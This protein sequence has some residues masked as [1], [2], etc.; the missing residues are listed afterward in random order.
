M[1]LP[2][3]RKLI[4]FKNN[5]LLS[6][7]LLKP[8]T[9]HIMKPAT[10]GEIIVIVVLAIAII[11]YLAR[12]NAKDEENTNPDLTDAIKRGHPPGTEEKED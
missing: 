7:Y 4:N 1:F 8:N 10:I 11:I 12:K 2:H 5:K 3:K 9:V 6:C